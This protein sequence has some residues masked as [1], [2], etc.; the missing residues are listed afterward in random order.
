ME[1]NTQLFTYT[2]QANEA[3]YKG[4]SLKK[5]DMN[6]D[7]PV[8]FSQE[9]KTA[10]MYGNYVHKVVTKNPLK[11]IN[12][13]SPYFQS[14]FMDFLN[15]YFKRYSNAYKTK[16]KLLVPIGLP[17]ERSQQKFLEEYC[18]IKP[19]PLQ[20]QTQSIYD[21][22]A[23]YYNRHRYSQ[24]D[25]DIEL[26]TFL[27]QMYSQHGF[28][29]YIAPCIWP[30]K[31]HFR[32]SDEICLFSLKSNDLI[33]YQGVKTCSNSQIGGSR[34]NQ[35]VVQIPP[36]AYPRIAQDSLDFLRSSGWNGPYELS[37]KGF[38]I[39]PHTHELV[40]H[41]NKLRK[42]EEIKLQKNNGFKMK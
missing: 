33:L 22:V 36:S 17:N 7:K 4:M 35:F 19:I 25:M 20:P 24:Q 34:K 29:G 6:Y 12:I 16:M 39:S 38:I 15:N 9:I 28:V 14:C 1:Q 23:F 31:Y 30:S 2:L 37:E 27:K 13:T 3:L 18:D 5:F 41:A 26:V 10:K 32:F 11:L 21:D 40:E 42:K 8:W